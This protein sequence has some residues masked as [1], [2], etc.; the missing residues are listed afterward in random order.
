MVTVRED[1]GQ[2]DGNEG[3]G[4]RVFLAEV[5]EINLGWSLV[6]VWFGEARAGW[7]SGGRGGVNWLKQQ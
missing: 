3:Q 5:E 1:G 4:T 7:G 2:L 6:G